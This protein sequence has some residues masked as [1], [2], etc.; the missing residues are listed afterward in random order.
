[1]FVVDYGEEATG[2]P[3]KRNLRTSDLDGAKKLIGILIE[4]QKAQRPTNPD[5]GETV[6]YVIQ[7]GDDGS[8][9]IGMSRGLKPRIAQLQNGNAEKLR[10]LRMYKMYDVERAIHAELEREARLEGERFPTDLLRCVDRFFNV[11]F[12]IASKRAQT[13]HKAI[14][15]KVEHLMSVGL[16]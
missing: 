16:L 6:L 2:K 5:N 8:I 13:R 9:K 1:M 4:Q 7:R 12:A 10:V 3:I 15:A 11:R 14:T